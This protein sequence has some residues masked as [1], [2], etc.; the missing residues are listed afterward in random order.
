MMISSQ[1]SKEAYVWIWL[2]E[3]TEPIVVLSLL[4]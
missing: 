3:K 2:P 1:Q 4:F